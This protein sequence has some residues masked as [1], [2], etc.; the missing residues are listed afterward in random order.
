MLQNAVAAFP[1]QH[2]EIDSKAR[3]RG[4][5][6][7]D[8]LKQQIDRHAAFQTGQLRRDVRE[9]TG[10]R[11]NRKRRNQAIEGFQDR[12][13]TLDGIRGGI[14]ANHGVST[15]IHKAIKR[16]QQD[17]AHVVGRVVGLEAYAEDA[18]LAHGVRQRVML[19]IFAA[20]STRSLFA[21]Q[22]RGSAASFPG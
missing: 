14:H 6:A 12:R 5:C 4:L 2:G 11:R 20:A 16:R 10:L 1:L 19:R 15:A 22:L 21:H 7:G 8:G 3:V 18:A 13:D 9:A 17:S